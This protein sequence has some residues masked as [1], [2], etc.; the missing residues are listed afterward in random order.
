MGA[1]AETCMSPQHLKERQPAGLRRHGNQD[2]YL[3]THRAVS[4][5]DANPK[6]MINFFPENQKHDMYILIG[7]KDS[8]SAKQDK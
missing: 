3:R 5:R 6:I 2:F 4:L 1:G 7:L 8:W